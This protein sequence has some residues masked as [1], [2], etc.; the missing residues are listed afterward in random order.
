MML[1][2]QPY[3]SWG[4]VY[5]VKPPE[6]FNFISLLITN[7]KNCFF[8]A[9]SHHKIYNSCW[10]SGEF[11]TGTKYKETE[12]CEWVFLVG[13]LTTA[14]VNFAASQFEHDLQMFIAKV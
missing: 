3:K 9:L 13:S 11:T 4:N 7:H 5:A 10:Y 8:Q 12:Q 14:F 1:L 2:C 6:V